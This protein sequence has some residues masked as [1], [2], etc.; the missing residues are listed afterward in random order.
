[1]GMG[2][3]NVKRYQADFHPQGRD[4]FTGTNMAT[5]KIRIGKFVR[6]E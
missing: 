1:M 5:R 4:G 2:S 6:S 3:C